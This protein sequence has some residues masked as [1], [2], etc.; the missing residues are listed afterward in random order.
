M[1]ADGIQASRSTLRSERQRCLPRTDCSSLRSVRR[2]RRSDDHSGPR[3]RQ[4][5]HRVTSA[6]QPSIL[7]T[8]PSVTVTYFTGVTVAALVS[9]YITRSC[10]TVRNFFFQRHQRLH[11]LCHTVFRRVVALIAGRLQWHLPVQHESQQGR[12]W[13]RPRRRAARLAPESAD[14]VSAARGG[15]EAARARHATTAATQRSLTPAPLYEKITSS[16][17]PCIRRP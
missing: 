13:P 8:Y 9:H 4:R 11:G 17:R 3:A 5:H 2:V 15:P 1:C 7:P 16:T 12:R 6:S 14:A 10:K